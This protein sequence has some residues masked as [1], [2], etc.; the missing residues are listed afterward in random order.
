V[1]SFRA[2][3]KISLVVSSGEV[4]LMLTKVPAPAAAERMMRF[5]TRC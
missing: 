3:K 2:V 4:T 1:S 5:P